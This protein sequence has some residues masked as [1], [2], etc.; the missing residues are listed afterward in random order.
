M[1]KAY[2]WASVHYCVHVLCSL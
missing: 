2:F 1:S